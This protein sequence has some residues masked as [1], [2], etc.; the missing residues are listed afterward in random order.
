M[1]SRL[2]TAKS[3]FIMRATLARGTG[4][5]QPGR[6]I[7]FPPRAVMS[8]A[9]ISVVIASLAGRPHRVGDARETVACPEAFHAPCDA[10]RAGRP[11]EHHPR[12]ELGTASGGEREWRYS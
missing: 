10:S 5:R 11:L 2:N 8:S 1:T 3:R 6:D 4:R 12:I 7:P 9:L